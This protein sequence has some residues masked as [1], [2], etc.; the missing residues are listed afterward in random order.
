M[1]RRAMRIFL[2]LVISLPA[3]AFAQFGGAQLERVEVSGGWTHLTG[4]N[5]LDGLN[6][7]AGYYVTNHVSVVGDF[8]FLW[9]TSK[10]SVFDLLP[11]TGAI[12]FKSNEQ[13]YLVGGRVRILG[14]KPLKTLEKR[15]I[16]PFGEILFGTSRLHQEVKDT[17]GTISAEASDRAFTWAFGGGVDYTLSAKWVARGRVDFVR[18]HFA[19]EGQS[20]LRLNLGLAYRF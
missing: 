17:A 6:A 5:G 16:L 8:D 10:S 1:K 18:T 7:G 14:F 3:T 9:D 19:D 20:R 2:F 15:K 12:T 4:N 11:S 13:N